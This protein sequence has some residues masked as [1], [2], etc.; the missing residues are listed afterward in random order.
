MFLYFAINHLLMIQIWV[1]G[2]DKELTAE[3]IINPGLGDT[4]GSLLCI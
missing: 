1:A 2:V 3:G 4:V